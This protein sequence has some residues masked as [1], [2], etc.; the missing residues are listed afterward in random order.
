MRTKSSSKRK[1]AG[2]AELFFQKKKKT[3]F[4]FRSC[5]V[6]K[7]QK[8][9]NTKFARKSNMYHP[10]DD[11]IVHCKWFHCFALFPI[12]FPFLFIISFAMVVFM[13]AGFFCCFHK[14][15]KRHDRKQKVPARWRC[16]SRFAVLTEHKMLSECITNCWCNRMNIERWIFRERKWFELCKW[17]RITKD[18]PLVLFV[19]LLI[20]LMFHLF[21][22]FCSEAPVIRS[23]FIYSSIV[24]CSLYFLSCHFIFF[25]FIIL[26]KS[27]KSLH[28]EMI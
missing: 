23:I 27:C 7:S 18:P 5:C 25:I 2:N 12:Y 3:N 22:D 14:V 6:V 17:N 19:L 11:A 10:G 4:F 8:G 21:S 26:L 24:T 1:Q 16:F 13:L 15:L 28:V 20:L 9:W